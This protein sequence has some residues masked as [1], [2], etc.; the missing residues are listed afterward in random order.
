MKLSRPQAKQMTLNSSAALARRAWMKSMGMKKL[1]AGRMMPT[2]KP[3]RAS[4]VLSP[5][6]HLP[7]RTSCAK[8]VPLSN[9]PNPLSEELP[10]SISPCCWSPAPG[11]IPTHL[12]VIFNDT[13]LTYAQSNGAANQLANGLRKLGVQRGEKV[14][15][16]C[17]N[18]PYFPIAY[19]AILKIGAAVVPFNV[20]FKGREVAYHLSDS[21]AVA[22]IAFQGTPD[23]PMAQM[24]F[25][26]F[27][28]APACRHL[29]VA[30]VDPAAAPRSR[31]KA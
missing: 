14:A 7:L 18:L 3:C 12:A 21:D 27:Q 4:V 25:D 19:Y 6:A 24:A 28:Q 20:L 5:L 17:P 9:L 22:M 15:L 23:L 26:G 10:C 31:A 16:S 13:K 1:L 11:P 8:I 30:T 29:I 2:M